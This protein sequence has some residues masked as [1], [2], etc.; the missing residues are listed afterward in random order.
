MYK[1]YYV[2]FI[3]NLHSGVA[4]VPCAL[5]QEI[6]LRPPLTKTA[7]FE[8]KN[9]FKSVERANQNIHWSY[10]VFFIKGMNRILTLENE[11]DKVVIV[12]RSN[13]AGVWG[14]NPQPPE[15]NGGS[16]AEPSMLRRFLQFF[17]K[18]CIF[19]HTLVKIS[20]YNAF[21]NA[22]KTLLLPSCYATEFTVIYFVD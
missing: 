5:G 16:G 10:F 1:L 9:S 3:F 20:A 17:Q 15:A 7:K 6:L 8:V 19:K 4:R 14:R 21:L 2:C 13:N 12:G 18:I 22:A 11:L